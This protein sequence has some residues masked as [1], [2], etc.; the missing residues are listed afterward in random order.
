MEMD[1]PGIVK[2]YQCM[3]DNK[4]INIVMELVKG[5]TLT[6]YMDQDMKKLIGEERENLCCIIIYQVMAACKYFHSKGIVHR[7]LKIDN[8]LI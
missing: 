4:Y 3:Y 1:H 8:I 7:D 5:K 2:F 6:D